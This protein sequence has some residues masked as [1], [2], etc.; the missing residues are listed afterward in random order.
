MLL[1]A[2]LTL[3]AL[4]IAP[5]GAAAAAP[6]PF[7]TR[8]VAETEADVSCSIPRGIA[9]AP[10]TAGVG[11]AG[12]VYVGDSLKSRIAEFSAWGALLRVWGWDVVASGP[13]DSGVGFEICVPA[14]GDVCKGGTQ[15]SGAG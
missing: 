5:S 14:D 12:N 7:W 10:A 4:A 9:T 8:C 6:E 1:L 2:A 11:V 13:G 15:G 3:A